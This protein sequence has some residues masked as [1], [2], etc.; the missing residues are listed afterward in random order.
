MIW[1]MI[2]CLAIYF[3][4]NVYLFIRLWQALYML[5]TV[6]RMLFAVIFWVLSVA[7]FVAIAARNLPLSES[8]HRLLH[9]A[10]ACWMVF[11]LYMVLLVALFDITH[12]LFSYPQHGVWYALGITTLLLVVGYINYRNPRIENLEIKTQKHLSEDIRI[13]AISDVHLGYG[14][15]RKALERYVDRINE[16]HPDVVLIAGDLIDNNMRPVQKAHME[17]ELQRIIAPKG[18]YM[19]AGNHEYISG[20]DTCRAFLSKTPVSLLRDSVASVA[21]GMVII[22]RDD[23]TNRHRKSLAELTHSVDKE[24]FS[25][26]VDHQPYDISE[27]ESNGIDLHISGHTH[28]GQVWP[29]SWLTDAIY[30]QS[31]GYRKW[32][33]THA[34]VL[35]GLSLWGPP[36]RIGTNSDILVVEVKE[37]SD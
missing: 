7:M 28:R 33:S 35:Q 12:A 37:V 4:A 22:G 14:T 20:I 18:V 6:W 31:H 27:S 11:L 19:V 15:S 25:I 29:I 10:G 17:Q 34:Y 3:G 21:D 24:M 16:L 30:D 1:G 36:F 8:L 13:V 32:S 23:R 2:A 9:N 26:V 5:P